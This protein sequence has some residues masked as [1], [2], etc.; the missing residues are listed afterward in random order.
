MCT[1]IINQDYPLLFYLTTQSTILWDEF[2]PNK[3]LKE[4]L[5]FSQKTNSLGIINSHS[6]NLVGFCYKMETNNNS[7]LL[8]NFADFFHQVPLIHTSSNAPL[9]INN[10]KIN[11]I[12]A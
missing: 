3:N 5:S 1:A 11:G 6:G 12:K 2:L 10:I 9:N 7:L 8:E 4:I